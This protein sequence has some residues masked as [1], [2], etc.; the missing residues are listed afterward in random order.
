MLG[1]ETTAQLLLATEEV[2][3]DSK[4]SYGQTPLSWAARNGHVAVVQL[5]LEK[6]ADAALGF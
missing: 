3:A 5:P 6:G 2:E 4:D 1:V